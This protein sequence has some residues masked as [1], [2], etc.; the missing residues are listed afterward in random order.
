MFECGKCG[1]KISEIATGVRNRNHCPACLWS[2]H[3]DQEVG[4]R[5]ASCQGLMKPI[6][7][8][9]RENRNKYKKEDVGELM[10]V[11]KCQSCDKESWCRVS[12]DDEPKK[13][14]ELAESL[15]A[16]DKEAVRKI[17]FGAN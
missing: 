4:D 13:I 12:G 1:T 5:K 8:K 11:H 7:L 6:G 9:F 16:D 15:G 2:K 14:N 3:V 10:I 17:L